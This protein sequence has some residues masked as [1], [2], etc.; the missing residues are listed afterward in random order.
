MADATKTI[1]VTRLSDQGS[2]ADLVGTTAEQRI[3]MMWQLAVDAWAMMGIQV[4][5]STFS[6][7]VE[8]VVRG[9]R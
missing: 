7:H 9:G 4:D 2:E 8:R 5:E 1:R 3:E 6:R